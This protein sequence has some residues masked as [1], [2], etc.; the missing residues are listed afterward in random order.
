MHTVIQCSISVQGTQIKVPKFHPS[1]SKKLHQIDVQHND[2]R[3]G[4]VSMGGGSHGVNA[5]I[6]VAGSEAQQW[7]SK[8]GI[9]LNGTHRNKFSLK[10]V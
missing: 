4:N 2:T 10:W 9:T 1:M 5:N 8:E 3:S 7:I 6:R